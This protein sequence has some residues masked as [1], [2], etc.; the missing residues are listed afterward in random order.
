MNVILSN[1]LKII[2]KQDLAERG[3]ITKRQTGKKLPF[4]EKDPKMISFELDCSN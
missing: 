2:H 3:E 4:R 1:N